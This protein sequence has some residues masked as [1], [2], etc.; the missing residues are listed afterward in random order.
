[1]KTGWSRPSGLRQGGRAALLQRS[2]KMTEKLPSLRR[3]PTRSR[4]R[5]AIKKD[6]RGDAGAF[7]LFARFPGWGIDYSLAHAGGVAVNGP[8]S[9]SMNG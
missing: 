4:R 9:R 7:L 1:M 2:E 5:S 6:Q 8:R 3:R